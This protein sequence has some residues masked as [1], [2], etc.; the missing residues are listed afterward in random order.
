LDKVKLAVVGCGTIS[1]LNAPGYLKYEKCDVV[2]L[3]DPNR[4]RAEYRAKTWGISPNQYS[5][6]QAEECVG[7]EIF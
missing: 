2:A 3:C 5:M 1:Q 4:D 7:A 6:K